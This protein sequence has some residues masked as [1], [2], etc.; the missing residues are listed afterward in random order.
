MSIHPMLNKKHFAKRR[1]R[2]LAALGSDAVAIIPAASEQVRNRDTHFTF[3]QNS[4]FRYL[5]GFD[6]PDAFLILA[7]KHELGASILFVRPRDAAREQ[8]DGRRAGVTGALKDYGVDQA[9][10]LDELDAKLP[11][12]LAGREQVFAPLGEDMGFAGRLF[13]WLAAVR[14]LQRAGVKAPGGWQ[15]SAPLLHE[16][17][18]FKD[19]DE[20]RVLREAC[21]ISELGHV[22]AMRACRPGAVE[23]ALEAELLHTF[24]QH[25]G[26]AAFPSI[27]AGGQ[28][29]CILHYTENRSHLNKGELVLVDAGCEW[30]G[31]CGDISRTL[32]VGGRFSSAQRDVYSVVLAAQQAAIDAVRPGANFIQPHEAAVQVLTEGLVDLKLLKGKVSKLIEKEAYKRFY[33]HR[34]GH[35]L[36]MDTH[37][38]GAYKVDGAWRALEPGMVLTVEPGL[39]IDAGRDVPK[40][41]RNI[42]I[43]IEDDVLVTRESHEVLTEAAPKSIAALEALVPHE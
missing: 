12:L 25:G 10:T 38:V 11:E 9:F 20:L 5:T 4:D 6:E 19:E 17:R 24:R 28:N 1:K 14:R 32:P 33:M 29:A 42:G 7:P 13:G 2:V 23:Y 43:R 35:W 36:G 22:A 39:Y 34:T 31:Y 37:D 21:R 30:G 41:L 27:V 18:L 26:E 40:E 15:D 8:W 16:M 3:R